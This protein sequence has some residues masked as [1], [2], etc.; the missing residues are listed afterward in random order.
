MRSGYIELPTTASRLKYAGVDGHY[1][2]SVTTSKH[3]S[4]SVT[5]SAYVLYFNAIV[6][7]PSNGPNYLWYGFSLRY[8]SFPTMLPATNYFRKPPSIIKIKLN[9]LPS[10]KKWT[11]PS[12]YQT[13]LAFS[14]SSITK[15][16]MLVWKTLTHLALSLYYI[17]HI[18]PSPPTSGKYK[19]NPNRAFSH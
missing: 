12:P 13:T 11:P 7:N 10:D 16:L 1:W 18:W 15:N 2:S 8:L 4:G 9:P 3:S 19:P 5:S 6:V 17:N 14:S